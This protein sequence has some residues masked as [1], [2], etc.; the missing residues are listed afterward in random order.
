MCREHRERSR[1]REVERSKERSRER[2][3]EREKRTRTRKHTMHVPLCC[4][5]RQRIVEIESELATERQQRQAAKNQ[6][7]ELR[8]SHVA[9]DVLNVLN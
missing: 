3:R 5:F 2:G 7:D 8:C 6:V 1:G 4:R 9:Y